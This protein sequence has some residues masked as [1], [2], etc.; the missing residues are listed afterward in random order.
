MPDEA[1]ALFGERVDG[2]KLGDEAR[3][4]RMIDGV[5][6]AGYV[7][8]RE[9]ESG[10]ALQ[11]RA[12]GE[13]CEIFSCAGGRGEQGVQSF[14]VAAADAWYLAASGKPPLRHVLQHTSAAPRRV[15]WQQTRLLRLSRE[16]LS[17]DR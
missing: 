5:D 3:N 1:G 4:L 11:M 2:V 17:T 7:D 9:V 16:G 8:L 15:L 13:G 6:Q 14:V 10:H 12:R